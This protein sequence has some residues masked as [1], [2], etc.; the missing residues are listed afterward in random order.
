M[1]EQMRRVLLTFAA[2]GAI[3]WPSA[4]SAF[5]DESNVEIT[6][7]SEELKSSTVSLTPTE[8]KTHVE[9]HK[10]EKE[11]HTNKKHSNSKRTT[12]TEHRESEAQRREQVRRTIDMINI[13]VSVGTSFGH[14]GGGG[15][16]GGEKH[17]GERHKD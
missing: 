15:G 12:R 8:E 16:G 9:H 5:V 2:L 3:A 6:H 7:K 10:P 13:G 1:G 4:S 11:H 17:H 14:G